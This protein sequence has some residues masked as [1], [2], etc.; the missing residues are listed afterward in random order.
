[1]EM[2]HP[3]RYK[4]TDGQIGRQTG[5]KYPNVDDRERRTADR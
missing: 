5:G 4:Q 2:A 1:M 3:H